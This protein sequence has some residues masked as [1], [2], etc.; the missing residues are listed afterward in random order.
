V[1]KADKAGISS[2]VDFYNK[3]DGVVWKPL[4]KPNKGKFQT[5]FLVCYN[6]EHGVFRIFEATYQKSDS[7]L[8]FWSKTVARRFIRD[9]QDLLSLYFGL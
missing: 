9:N 7:T 6:Q 8:Y 3:V 1:Q 2:I 5:K 4:W